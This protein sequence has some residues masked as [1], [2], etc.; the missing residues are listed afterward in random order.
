M[1]AVGEGLLDVIKVLVLDKRVDLYAT[2]LD[3]HTFACFA[4]EMDDDDDDAEG[5]GGEEVFEFLYS[6]L[7][8]SMIEEPCKL[9]ARCGTMLHHAANAGRYRV[10]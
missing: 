9:K 10:E 3:G 2:S 4:A 5:R 8:P 6:Q 7:G 1:L